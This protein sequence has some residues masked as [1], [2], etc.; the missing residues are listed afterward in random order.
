[1]T[2]WDGERLG[3]RSRVVMCSGSEERDVVCGSERLRDVFSGAIGVR[4]ILTRLSIVGSL[5]SKIWR[6]CTHVI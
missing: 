6:S 3:K 2:S 5:M 1:M 4:M